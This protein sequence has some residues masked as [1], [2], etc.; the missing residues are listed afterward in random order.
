MAVGEARGLG[1][2]CGERFGGDAVLQVRGQGIERR[3]SERIGEKVSHP[4][5][6][7]QAKAQAQAGVSRSAEVDPAGE[8]GEFAIHRFAGMRRELLRAPG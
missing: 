2:V 7:A 6:A 8:F 5:T 1:R 4:F 3:R